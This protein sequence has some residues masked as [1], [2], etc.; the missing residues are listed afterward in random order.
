M[1]LPSGHGGT[2][3]PGLIGSL[4]EAGVGL[5]YFFVRGSEW[6]LGKAAGGK[7]SHFV[8]REKITYGKELSGSPVTLPKEV[9]VYDGPAHRSELLELALLAGHDSRF[10]K[11]TSPPDGLF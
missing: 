2:D 6:R 9:V 3:I 1:D 8:R 7:G 5:A 4:R 11:R 10:R